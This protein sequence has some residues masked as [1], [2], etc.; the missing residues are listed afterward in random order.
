MTRRRSY[1]ETLNSGRERR[2]DSSYEELNRALDS[3]ESRFESLTSRR[4]AEPQDRRP[5]ERD[6]WRPRSADLSAFTRDVDRARAQEDSLAAISRIASDLT[7]LRR[8]LRGEMGHAVSGQFD[9]LRADIEAL[10]AAASQG[11]TDPAIADELQRIAEALRILT[12]RRDDRTLSTIAGEI[13]TLRQTV[14]DLARE[15]TL[16][17]MAE[18]WDDFGERFG[19]VERRLASMPQTDISEI[20]RRLSQII[21]AVGHLPDS[22]P[23]R[24]LE[25]KV[26]TLAAAIDHFSRSQDPQSGRSI[27]AI[28]ER[29]D[30][31]SRALVAS[32]VATPAAYSPEPFERI[33][34]R[35]SSLARQIE[36]SVGRQQGGDHSAAFASLAQ[37]LDQIA[38]RT[39]LPQRA[40]ERLTDQIGRIG[41]MLDSAMRAD[42]G[43][44]AIRSF[45]QRFET[46]AEAL[47]QQQETTVRQNAGNVRA[48]EQRIE[49]MIDRIDPSIG[50]R[51]DGMREAIESR[52]TELSRRIGAL[53]GI[54]PNAVRSLENRLDDIAARLDKARGPAQVIDPDLVRNLEAQ[55][56]G[57]S[58]LLSRPEQAAALP[59]DIAIRLDRMEDAIALNRDQLLDAARLAAEEAVRIAP[60]NPNG[61][62]ILA[63]ADDLKTLDSLARRSDE[64]NGKTFEAIHETLLKIVDRLVALEKG[65]SAPE[66][67]TAKIAVENVPSLAHEPHPADLDEADGLSKM[68]QSARLGR[69]PAEAAT[70]A[71]FAALEGERGDV[72]A[73]SKPKKTSLLGG[74]AQA[75]GAGRKAAAPAAAGPAS[76]PA[77]PIDPA[78]ADQPLEPGSGSPDLHAI[79]RRVR[80][81]RRTGAGADTAQSDFVAAARRAA[82]AAA[83]EAET[84]KKRADKPGAKRAGLM[85]TLTQ[86]RKPILMAVGAIIIAMSGLTLSKQFLSDK[87]KAQLAEVARPDKPAAT[88]EAAALPAVRQAQPA[89]V[90][91]AADPASPA[92]VA[93]AGDAAEP[94]PPAAPTVTPAAA[95]TLAAAPAEPAPA[96][97]MAAY[98]P[99]ANA[100]PAALVAAAKSGDP[101]AMFEIATRYDDGRN[102]TAD[103]KL[104]AEWFQHAADLGYAP[105]QYRVGNLY[106]KGTGVARDLDK[107][108]TWYQMAAEQGNAS[109]MHN[110]AV[111]FA[112]GTSGEA[113]NESAARWFRAAADVGVKDSQYNLG[114]MA[115]KGIG[116][117][118]DLVESYKWFALAAKSGDKDAASKRDEIAKALRPEQLQKARADTELWQPKALDA[119]ANTVEM[120]A[121]WADGDG[122][123]ASVDMTKAIRNIQ[124]ILNKNGYDAGS[125]DGVMGG[126]TKAAIAAWQQAHG[127]A[128]TGEID[129]ALV[130]SLLAK[131]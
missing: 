80:E 30:E 109:A 13:E 92:P 81:E 66:P 69:T 5:A 22:L 100:G 65:G 105:A 88:T 40:I 55:V 12:E 42:T 84:V 9:A 107:A 98:D 114:V 102:G 97:D 103:A 31:I 48:L 25:E 77:A 16:R 113:D 75:I 56:A 101:K 86:H 6:G 67:R 39:E 7:T 27:A 124:T 23:I 90:T 106:E 82:Q 43:V 59:D 15:D 28:E 35:I 93:S 51:D 108:K 91:P 129:E 94:A 126:K 52:F 34:A 83:A 3:L 112:T 62:A 61:A 17:G 85:D 46:L 20:D 74:I 18:R 10:Y 110:L 49:E 24:S 1:L 21:E 130:R 96:E 115:A 57:L 50:G 125:A 32:A 29:L 44:E 26:R 128:A 4:T 122:K 53:G 58:A 68:R 45:E 123:T 99:P 116:M 72:A 8:D 38:E 33:E 11:R 127:M 121:S 119:A 120:P 54:D 47:Q 111:L 104:A 87:P 63:L 117:T 14:G 36:E 41:Q 64:R 73:A 70:E 76:A 60:G 79:M 131:K 78:I 19:A 37:R 89:P 118:Q 2:T 95:P 71:A